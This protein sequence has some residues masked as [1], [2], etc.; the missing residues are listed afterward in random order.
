M[1]MPSWAKGPW[2]TRRGGRGLVRSLWNRRRGWKSGHAN[3]VPAIERLDPR[4]AL[5]ADSFAGAPGEFVA[6]GGLTVFVAEDKTAGRELWITDGTATGTRVLKDVNPGKASSNPAELTVIGPTLF[7]AADNGTDGRELWKSDGTAAGTV[8]VKDVHP[9]KEM[10]Y[11]WRF[12]K[13]VERI[14]WADPQGL[15]EFEG[16]L[17]FAANDGVHGFE[18][19]S[20]D[21]TAQGTK[22]VKDIVPESTSESSQ[23]AVPAFVVGGRLM[24]RTNDGLWATDGTD[25][26]T[27]RL[28]PVTPQQDY[29]PGNKVSHARLGGKVVF[30]G[31]DGSGGGTEPWITDGTA[32]GTKLL[33][34]I[35]SPAEGTFWNDPPGA[36][37][38]VGSLV[39]FSADDGVH[40]TELWRTDGTTAGTTMVKDI[41]TG[42]YN[43][44]DGPRPDSSWPSGIVP[45]A[46]G[47]LFSADDGVN[48]AELWKSDGTA[49]GTVLVKDLVPGST[50]NPSFPSWGKPRYPNSGYPNSITPFKDSFYFLANRGDQL[51]KTDGTT[52]GTVL[53]KDVD[54]AGNGSGGSGSYGALAVINGALLF[55]AASRAT[56]EGTWT[57]DGSAAGTVRM[58]DVAPRVTSVVA[59]AAGTRKIG[60]TITFQVGFTEPVTVTGRPSVP[61]TVGTRNL[62]AAYQS[63]SGTRTLSFSYTVASGLVDTDGIVAGSSIVAS[64]GATI[65]N[66]FRTAARTDLPM[67]PLTGVLVDAVAPAVAGITPPANRDYK[68]GDDLTFVVRFTKGVVVTGTPSLQLTIG[69]VSRQ[70][71]FVSQQSADSLRF[72]Y[73]L[74]PSDPADT[75]GIGLAKSIALGGGTIRDTVGNAAILTFK[76]PSLAKVRVLRAAVS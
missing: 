70:A 33:A 17:Y 36:F 22:L 31:N 43:S 53:V 40:G 67:S 46:G 51:W 48:G 76:V 50:K 41:A 16:K 34:D 58:R 29:Q 73:R 47:I 23:A 38:A 37:T 68:A 12:D 11:D 26:G 15:L 59:P 61:I 56:G 6:F 44:F 4:V 19:W 25:A 63:G 7:F 27:E 39:Y 45:F 20:S 30:A 64:A 14:A 60:D 1:V 10:V 72:E 28:G 54:G 5:A 71:V 24:V 52:A 32:A 35:N 49:S 75:N 74:L 42:T 21:G 57:S 3:M 55:G 69:N 2:F 62:Q 8:L 66:A 18:V 9:G 65:R 13:D